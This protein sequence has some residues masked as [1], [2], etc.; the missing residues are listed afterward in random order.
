MTDLIDLRMHQH[1]AHEIYRQQMLQRLPDPFP[2]MLPV[3][4][5]PMHA[6]AL[7]PR[8][9]LPGVELKLQN[10]EL[11][12]DFHKIGTEMIITKSGRRMFPSMRLTVDGLDADTNYCVL[13]EMMPI[14]D[15]RFKF[16][17][18][19]WVPAGGAEPQS[20][21]RFCL[22]P[23]SPAL[24][25][26]WASQPIVFNKVKLTNNT[27]DNNG[28]VVLTSMHKYQ[29]R[30]HII[31]TSDPSQIPWAAQQAFVFPETEFVAVTAYQNDRI[32]KL[33]IDNNPF[34]KG[35][36]ETGQS[37]CKR[38]MGCNA[39][40]SSSSS[41][42]TSSSGAGGGGGGGSGDG[43]VDG[44]GQLTD[45][46]DQ[47][48]LIAKR[49]RSNGSPSSDCNAH[50]GGPSLHLGRL[51]QPGMRHFPPSPELL[52]RHY[53]QMFNPGWMDLMLPYFARHP[54]YHHPQAGQS[55][56]HPP[57]HHH[58]PH[59]HLLQHHAQPPG[60]AFFG[61]VGHPGHLLATG[62]AQ[63]PPVRPPVVS[64]AHSNPES[65]DLDRSSAFSVRTPQTSGSD[66]DVSERAHVHVDSPEGSPRSAPIHR[67]AAIRPSGSSPASPS[68]PRH[69]SG[70]PGP[71][72]QPGDPS[73]DPDRKINF[74]IAS[75]L[76]L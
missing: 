59:Q 37:R 70:E 63:T 26:H 9:S 11:W 30:I 5:P 58:Q 7:P 22:H 32:T 61:P 24:G 31:R 29:P 8:Y 65:T 69:L 46:E 28:H 43:G 72:D 4:V 10:K 18:S 17:G 39:S 23:D 47:H 25:T 6:M 34:A 75:I 16:S 50:E 64:P 42:S 73:G 57:H 44:G 67:P 21:Q 14:S 52:M 55:P 49:P 62:G 54:P 66:F 12:R 53:N 33:K 38:K 60:T 1:I 2:T 68:S 71:A 76:L 40:T 36:R 19:Q 41:S 3:P 13:L 51:H 20:P 35:F 45:D 56:H 74:S 48:E 15:C 27:L